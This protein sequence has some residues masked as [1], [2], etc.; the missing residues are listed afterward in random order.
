MQSRI[1]QGR[2]R[3]YTCPRMRAALFAFA[4]LFA[5][6]AAADR[7]WLEYNGYGLGLVPLGGI[8]VD[9]DVDNERYAV[10]ATL[11]SRGLLN[12]FERTHLVATSQGVIESGEVRWRRY[13]LDH[14]YSRK[15]RVINMTAGEGG[16]INAQ[17]TPNYRLWGE[18][19]ASEEQRRRSRDP[20][21]TMVA[22]AVDVG[23]TRRCS[24][25][26]PTFDGR[27]HYLMELAGGEL[28]AIDE[29]GYEGDVLKCSL[30]YIAVAGFEARDAG[31]RRIP[32]GEVWF[33]LMP[34]TAF[35]PPVRITT[36]ISAG[37]AVIRLGSFR[38]ARVDVELTATAP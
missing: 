30:A 3:H 25:V 13:D 27:F 33:A 11:Q 36:P 4:L 1:G 37:G 8:A 32:H 14:R 23:Q 5:T 12:L 26:Y 29:A 28:D 15:R 38:R 22:M 31:R 17:I 24:G 10:T 18:P 35:A 9:A 20:L 21:S 16:A 19:P 6:P 7:F 2:S 34:D